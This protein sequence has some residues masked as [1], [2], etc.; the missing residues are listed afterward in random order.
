M[1][2][3]P[4]YTEGPEAFQRFDAAMRK[5]LTVSHEEIKRR[6]EADN[7]AHPRKRGRP[8]KSTSA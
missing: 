1:K 2:P 3:K 5:A 8:Q 6:V 4:E 7:R